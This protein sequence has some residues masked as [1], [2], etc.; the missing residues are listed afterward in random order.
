MIKK[1]EEARNHLNV[2]DMTEY[3]AGENSW[4]LSENFEKNCK[5]RRQFNLEEDLSFS[6]DMQSDEDDC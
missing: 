5:E 2:K 4:R 1:A 3:L 6:M